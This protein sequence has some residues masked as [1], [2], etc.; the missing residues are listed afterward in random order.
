[1]RSKTMSKNVTTD[2]IRPQTKPGDVGRAHV[3]PLF[4]QAVKQIE[5][6]IVTP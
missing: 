1:M 6:T 2:Q 4:H 5:T 3:I